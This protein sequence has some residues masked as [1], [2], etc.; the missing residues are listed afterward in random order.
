MFFKNNSRFTGADSDYSPATHLKTLDDNV[1]RGFPGATKQP[2]IF[3]SNGNSFL[4]KRDKTPPVH[5]QPEYKKEDHYERKKRT[6]MSLE[7]PER[8]HQGDREE[9]EQG[10]KAE[11]Q[12]T[13][14][15]MKTIT[16]KLTNMR[17]ERD[18][19]QKDNKALQEEVLMLQA[20]FRQMIPGF[21]NTSGSF[22]M[23]NEL[24]TNTAEFYK[25][26]CED[27]FF[28]LLCPEL[29]MK[30]VIFFFKTAFSRLVEVVEG[31]FRPSENLLKKTACMDTLEGPL[32]NALRKGYQSTWK[33][34]VER[35]IVPKVINDIIRE[36]QSHLKLENLSSEGVEQLETFLQKMGEL[37]VCF[38]ISDPP[39]A[40]N[41]EC[42]GD[43]VA[44]N[45]M[46][47]EA[48]DGFIKGKEECIVVLPS[49]HKM[50]VDGELVTK[51]LVLSV[52]YEILN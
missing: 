35:C 30:G 43:K 37:M 32:M 22:P 44:F 5:R 8:Y 17:K 28:D 1:S 42:I 6:E 34:I 40:I 27:L 25:C 49:A 24:I 45:P 21:A 50:N 16:M 36:I 46:K 51:A 41:Y 4:S 39:L 2:S 23:L 52:G 47:H 14:S 19:L 13:K 38:Y 29:S 18:Q 15:K 9:D 7:S 12:E 33:D 3:P 48:L 20:S 26:E 11:L 10:L 31:Y